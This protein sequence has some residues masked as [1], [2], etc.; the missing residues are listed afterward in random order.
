MENFYRLPNG[1]KIPAIGFGTYRTSA[2][3]TAKQ[4][5][6]DALSAGYR[7]I[8]CAAIY[9]NESSVGEAIEESGLDRSQLFV[10]SK[11]WN[12]EKG[13]R[14]T[15]Q[16]FE[17]TIEDLKL[18]YLDLYLIHWPIAKA[19]KDDWRKA[20]QETWRALEELYAMGR[21]RAIGVSNFRK[22]HLLSLMNYATI[23]PMVNQIE[24]HPGYKQRETVEFCKSSN[25][26]VEAWAPLA[27]GAVFQN[28]ELKRL[29]GLYGKTVSQI[30]L[31]WIYQK[32]IVPLPKSI[33]PDRIMENIDIFDFELQAEDVVC[34]DELEEFGFS[35][36]DPDD[37][38]F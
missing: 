15:Y 26:M 4:S 8:D 11:L 7:S 33:T 37:L 1:V 12:D 28:E 27:N 35:G 25:L 3:K 32:G 23:Q 34:I 14:S 38:D 2:G 22:N 29:A 6:A 13:Y 31:R 30:V 5:V 10:T 16:A 21:I 18:D 36:L 24:F 9:R 19:T 20:N 17:K